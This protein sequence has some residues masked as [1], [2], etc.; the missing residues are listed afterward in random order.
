MISNNIS[1]ACLIIIVILIILI[2]ILIIIII[3]ILIIIIMM[4]IISAEFW[5]V[6]TLSSACSRFTERV[7]EVPTTK[8]RSKVISIDL[9]VE[10][11]F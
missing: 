10:K 6:V 5:R 2:T 11:I 8:Y 7:E 4:I 9:S 1:T 3:N